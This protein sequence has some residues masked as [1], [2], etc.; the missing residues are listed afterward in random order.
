MTL[1]EP[2]FR[3]GHIVWGQRNEALKDK[4]QKRQNRA[5]RVI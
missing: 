4:L 5:A 2:R 1:V 3:Y